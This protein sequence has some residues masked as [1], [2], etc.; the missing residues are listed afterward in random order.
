MELQKKECDEGG[1]SDGN[2][3]ILCAKL[4]QHNLPICQQK[5]MQR[6]KSKISQLKEGDKNI[7]FF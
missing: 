1:L 5:S 6:Q 2:I 7:K 4:A 3:F